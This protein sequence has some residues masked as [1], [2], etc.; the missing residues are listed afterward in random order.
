MSVLGKSVNL[1]LM[2]R[3]P[4]GRWQVKLSNW[5]GLAYKIFRNELKNCA[6]LTEINTPGIYFLF[7]KDDESGKKFIYI[8][9]ADD[10][11]KRISQPH[12]FEKDGSYW[13]EAIT[14]VTPDGTLE[15]GRVKYLENR[16]YM[17]AKEAGRYI[18]KNGNTPTQS[19]MS[20]QI[21]DMLEEFIN[22]I[23]FIL[24]TLGYDV[25]DCNLNVSTKKDTNKEDYLYFI[26]NNGKGGNAVGKITKEGFWI[27]KGSYIYPKVAEYTSSGIKRDRK[28]YSKY[29]DSKGI[30]QENLCFGSPSYASTFV[31]GKNSNG[32]SE[33]KN[34]EGCSLKE[35]NND[36]I[37]KE[38]DNSFDLN[39]DEKLKLVYKKHYAYGIRD[40]KGLIVL[41]DSYFCLEEK[42][43]CSTWI[44]N[45]RKEIIESGIIKN[46]AFIKD[47]YFK[48][49]SAAAACI[50]GS[51][52]NGKL[53]WLFKDKAIIDN[54]N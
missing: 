38:D 6:D 7:G 13:N 42:K 32:L 19:P 4:F 14:F 5:N 36:V 26:R 44:K 39:T 45:L 31:C 53:K 37:Y 33:W 2:D 28:L 8:G 43:S 17:I 9:E 15:K 50:I 25:F 49:P 27:L 3:T 40:G 46:G 41:K 34:K 22:N 1:Y 29:I 47:Y 51:N 24:S 21:T 54:K 10:V 30:L 52:I 12:T 48:S 16:F 35:I 18:I 20:K 11:L 23:K